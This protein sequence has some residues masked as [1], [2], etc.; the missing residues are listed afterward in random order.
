MKIA[1]IGAGISGLVAGRTLAKAGFEVVVFEKSRGYGG[2]MATRYAGKKHEIKLDHGVSYLEGKS[3]EF[4]A[5]LLELLEEG[6]TKPWSGRH[7][8]LE[9]GRYMEYYHEE[10]RAVAL[11]GMNSI[12]RYL[13]RLVDVRLEEKV[14]GLTF[15][16][17]DR[18]K[19]RSWMLNLE[20]SD[21]FQ[22]DAVIIATPSK[23]A[24]SVLNTTIDEVSTLKIVREIDE[25]EYDPMF[26]LMAGYDSI[27]ELDWDMLDIKD[28]VLGWA[29]VESSKRK[30]K[31]THLVVHSTPDFARKHMEKREGAEKLMLEEM[32]ELFGDWAG[33]PDWSQLHFWRYNQA[34]NP[35]GV[36]YIDLNEMEKPLAVVG[37]YMNGNSV[38]SAYLSGLKLA[39]K[40]V[41][42]FNR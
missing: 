22:A 25:V 24:Y 12:G 42:E 26:V 30:M 32:T 28:S 33:N 7:M 41:E 2:R 3:P 8:L 37:S 21:T 4:R 11:D 29:A 15:I 10:P 1:I 36:P 14:G 6:L 35:L 34:I 31:K 19:K 13:A 20:S 5:F 38:E 39:E 18:R 40:W 17:D 23:Q 27:P 9:D 16:G